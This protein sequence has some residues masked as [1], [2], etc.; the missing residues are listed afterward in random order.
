MEQN[1]LAVANVFGPPNRPVFTTLPGSGMRV[2][3]GSGINLYTG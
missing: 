1:G 2:R 3:R